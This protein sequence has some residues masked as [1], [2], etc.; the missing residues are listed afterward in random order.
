MQRGDFDPE[1]NIAHNPEKF[2]AYLKAL[3]KKAEEEEVR[4]EAKL[5]E[6][7]SR[8]GK[9][10]EERLQEDRLFVE[11]EKAVEEAGKPDLEIMKQRRIRIN[12]N[13]LQGF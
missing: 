7:Y 3:A 6:F 8:G 12:Y 4:N 10:T 1:N 5:D 13:L 2:H 9:F 11:M